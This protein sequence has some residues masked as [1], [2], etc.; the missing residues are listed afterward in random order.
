MKKNCKKQ[1]KKK[2]GKKKQLKEK[3]V[4]YMKNGQVMIIHLIV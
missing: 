4:N 1:I 2:L 3:G